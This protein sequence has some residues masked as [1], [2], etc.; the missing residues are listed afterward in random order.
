MIIVIVIFI[1]IVAGYV[2]R[3][4]VLFPMRVLISG[5]V[6]CTER[7]A[8]QTEDGI[9]LALYRYR[10][11]IK[12]SDCPVIMCHGMATNRFHLDNG[13]DISIARFFQAAGY[14]TWVVELRGCGQSTPFS[15]ILPDKRFDFDHYAGQ[16]VP[17]I[18]A[19]VREQTRSDKVHWLGHSMGGMVL[20][21][22]VARYGH[23][24]L[25]SAMIIGSPTDFSA[26]VPLHHRKFWRVFR[27]FCMLL[28]S[29]PAGTIARNFFP[30]LPGLFR[31]LD[32]PRPI[33]GILNL[34]NLNR[35]QQL[36]FFGTVVS[37]LPR[38][39]ILQ[40]I[41]WVI[42][43][44][45]TSYDRKIN[46]SNGLEQLMFPLFVAASEHDMTIPMNTVRATFDRAP[47]IDKTLHI[48]SPSP[49]EHAE[50]GHADMVH[51]PACYT[52]FFP[53]LL[54]WLDERDADMRQK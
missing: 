12:K 40:A 16:D 32:W 4:V 11:A 35:L 21:A 49:V 38:G 29:I 36:R 15:L 54:T 7:H 48:L 30:I 9:L 33:L 22:Y 42:E 5:E 47:T 1:F 19:Y 6:P 31:R 43:G 8:V 52:E 34:D 26:F 46:Y 37:N 18:I 50:F 10:P 2:Y 51:C 24:A 27:V 53:I 45:M 20:V 39:L 3:R 25:A 14:D 44:D 23:D 13:A 28:P 17:A 41:R